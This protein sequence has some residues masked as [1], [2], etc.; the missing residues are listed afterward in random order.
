MRTKITNLL[1]W[2]ALVVNEWSPCRLSNGEKGW[3]FTKGRATWKGSRE[4][5]IS[6]LTKPHDA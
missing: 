6:Q 3:T 1:L 5:A 4:Y 2:L